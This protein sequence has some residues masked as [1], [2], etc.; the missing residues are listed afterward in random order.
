MF[1]AFQL[2][3]HNGCDGGIPVV[4]SSPN[5]LGRPDLGDGSNQ[6]AYT[7]DTPDG[8]LYVLGA[9]QAVGPGIMAL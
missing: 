6:F 3:Q 5:L 7:A 2:V 4:V 9:L 1:Q 8:Y